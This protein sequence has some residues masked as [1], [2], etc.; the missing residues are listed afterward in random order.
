MTFS[1]R[2]LPEPAAAKTAVMEMS[3]LVLAR[4]AGGTALMVAGLYYLSKGKKERDL[5]K[6]ITGAVLSL[7]AVA[8]ASY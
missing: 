3:P 6:M 7:L 4:F 1:S 8:V 2:N 5:S